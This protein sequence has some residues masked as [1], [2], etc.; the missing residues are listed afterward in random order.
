MPRHAA[1]DKYPLLRDH[2]FFGAIGTAATD[3]LCSFA[4]TRTVGRG[5][6][7]FAK[8][9]AG[10]TLFVVCTGTVKIGIRSADGRYAVFSL[11][12]ADGMFGE[13]ALL[14][15]R[16]RSADATA[17]TDCDLM[18]IDRRD[19]VPLIRSEPEMAIPIIEVLCA[20]LRQ[21]SEQMED[22]MFLDLPGRLAKA[23]LELTGKPGPADSGHTV[24]ITQREIGE[25]IG[26]SREST[27]KQLRSWEKLQWVRLKAGSIEVLARGALA[28]IVESN[29]D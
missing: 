8:G 20:R 1:F 18:A 28:T 19:M 5:E 14:D 15:G 29:A 12:G 10:H 23:L 24:L 2:P 4:S 26:M 22:M 21:T 27:N 25:I 13:M 17:V 3:R 7:I 11:I 6:T 9:D 16:P